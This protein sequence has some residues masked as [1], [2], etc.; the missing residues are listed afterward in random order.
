MAPNVPIDPEQFLDYISTIDNADIPSTLDRRRVVL[1]V[2]TLLARLQSPR[3]KTT[4]LLH[5][6]AYLVASVKS[7]VNLRLFSIWE[8]DGAQPKT[9]QQLGHLTGAD[10]ALLGRQA[11][12]PNAFFNSSDPQQ[13]DC[14]GFW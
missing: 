4:Q 13:K 10:P 1:G 7:L 14:S 12:S 6:N 9:A 8:Q 3:E 5:T 2:Q 11:S